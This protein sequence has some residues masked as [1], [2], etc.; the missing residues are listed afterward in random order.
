M[1][2]KG[3]AQIDRAE[4]S[5]ELKLQN[6]YV[7]TKITPRLY[8]DNLKEKTKITPFFLKMKIT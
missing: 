3:P 5:C 2:R 8:E 1:G 7:E 4:S 6:R